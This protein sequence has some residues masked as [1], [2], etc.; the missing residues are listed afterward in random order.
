MCVVSRMSKRDLSGVN[1]ESASI[2]L[3]RCVLRIMGDNIAR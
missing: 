2:C 1:C 3:F